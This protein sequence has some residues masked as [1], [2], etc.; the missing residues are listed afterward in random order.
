MEQR[1]A[2]RSTRTDFTPDLAAQKDKQAE[3]NETSKLIHIYI[4]LTTQL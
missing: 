2:R 3:T 4:T 1:H